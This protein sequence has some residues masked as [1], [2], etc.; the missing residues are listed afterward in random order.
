MEP[1]K[2]GP[3]KVTF[4][5]AVSFDVS[6]SPLSSLFALANDADAIG[7]SRWNRMSGGRRGSSPGGPG[8]PV[9]VGTRVVKNM[10]YCC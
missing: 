6:M 9:I 5:A 2:M 1:K 4:P 7:A 3:K 8:G 10:F